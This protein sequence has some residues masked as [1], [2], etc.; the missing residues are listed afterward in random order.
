MK[1]KFCALVQM[2]RIP[3]LLNQM[4][5]AVE[6][7]LLPPLPLLNLAVIPPDQT[8]LAMDT[9]TN[10]QTKMPRIYPTCPMTAQS[11]NVK[12]AVPCPATLQSLT[13]SLRGGVLINSSK[14]TLPDGVNQCLVLETSCTAPVRV[15]RMFGK[16]GSGEQKISPASPQNR[17]HSALP[18]T[19]LRGA[20]T[21]FWRLLQM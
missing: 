13:A 17:M 3:R 21:L 9:Q 19:S 16:A 4:M 20:V 12:A 10:T 18:P 8:L 15:G 7:L 5:T 11:M 6:G 1:P 2:Q 14:S